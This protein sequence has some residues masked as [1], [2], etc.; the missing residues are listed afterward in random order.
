MNYQKY[1]NTRAFLLYGEF[2]ESI[3]TRAARYSFARSCK[4]YV[5]EKGELFFVS[6]SRK[7]KV[8]KKEHFQQALSEHHSG[9]GAAHHG[10]NETRKR[11]QEMFYWETMTEDVKEFCK[12]LRTMS[13]KQSVYHHPQARVDA[14]HSLKHHV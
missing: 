1:Q 3:Q 6:K 5:C 7:M 2:P 13:T 8:L 14:N 10:V 12:D 4:R 9:F 11:L